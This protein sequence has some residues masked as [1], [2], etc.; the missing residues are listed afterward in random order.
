MFEYFAKLNHSFAPHPAPCIEAVIMNTFPDFANLAA[1]ASLPIRDI[2]PEIDAVLLRRRNAVVTAPPGSGKTSLVPL[3]L[4]RAPWRLGKIW[5]VAPRRV[6]VRNAA[7]RM[8]KL[9]GEATGQKIGFTTRVERVVSARTEIEVM[10]EG[11]FLRRILTD[12]FLDGVDAVIFD[13]AHERSLDLDT[14]LAL[15]LSAQKHLRTDLRVIVMSATLEGDAF[16]QLMDAE[17]IHC[18]GREYPLTIQHITR[19]LQKPSDLPKA[20]SLQIR[21]ALSHVPLGN[22]LVFLPGMREIR[23]VERLI[24]DVDARILPLHGDLPTEAQDLVFSPSKKRQIILATSI[25]ETSLTLPDTRVVI[26]GGFRRAPRWDTATGLNRLETMRISKAAAQQRAGRAGREGPGVAIRLW[27]EALHRGL[28]AF[29]LPEILAA[30]VSPLVMHFAI[31]RDVTGLNDAEDYLLQTPSRG[32]IE[33]AQSVLTAIGAMLNHDLTDFGRLMA[34]WGAHPRLAAILASAKTPSEQ[35]AAS[36]LCALLEER[37]PLRRRPGDRIGQNDTLS[38]DI[39]LRIDVLHRQDASPVDRH[40]VQR[41]RRVAK[42]Y[43]AAFGQITGTEYDGNCIGP[44]LAAGFPDRI[45]MAMDGA[46][47]YRLAGGGSAHLPITDPLARS[48]FLV[49]PSLHHSRAT[50]IE[51]AAPVTIEELPPAIANTI[52]NTR[53]TAL[54]PM[55]G[56][57]ISREKRRLGRLLVSEKD[58]NVV[59]EDLTEL[60]LDEVRRGLR[61][62]LNWTESCDQFQARIELGRG[63]NSE[64]PLVG[65]AHL[66]AKLEDWLSPWITDRKSR[67]QLGALD[68]LAILKNL[69]TWEQ[70]KWLDTHLPPRLQLPRGYV[71]IDYTSPIPTVAARAQMFYGCATTPCIA[72]NDVKLQFALLS[73]AGRVQAITSDLA[74]FWRTGWLDMRRDMRGRYP[75][76]DWPEDPANASSIKVTSRKTK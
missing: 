57:V 34:R 44:L 76:H 4:L 64:L 23:E 66:V 41:I 73:P 28:P 60:L 6:A 17:Q 11:L 26:D 45:A 69:L 2:L 42:R 7:Q 59:E 15:T 25:A 36:D 43:L 5:L 27:S 19:E 61:Q 39:T 21:R 74:S 54:D 71:Q 9:C 14:S 24:D 65:D 72:A 70:Q 58:V 1:S 35:A 47:R 16:S 46:G 50:R 31:W 38:S 3:S 67:A 13:E 75:K 22:I 53:E 10:T 62:V 68:L 40:S 51:L 18:K 20:A 37:D 8:A 30:D 52:V 29:D 12:P 48:R 32:A 55:T 63:L 33:V 56:R 49:I